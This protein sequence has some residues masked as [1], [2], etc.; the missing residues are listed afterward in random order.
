MNWNVDTIT[1]LAEVVGA[2]GVIVSLFYL[3]IQIRVN[4]KE[5]RLAAMHEISEGFRDSISTFTNAEMAG[6][7]TRGNEDFD[8]LSDAEILQL[9]AGYQ[10]M[11]RLWEEAFY[12][13]NAGRLDAVIWDGIISEYSSFLPAPSFN[14]IWLLRRDYFPTD[15]QTLVDE[16]M[17][18]H[19]K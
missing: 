8:A 15:F 3:A 19:Q 4:N 12:Q 9:T 14:R 6:V 16:L 11:L 7:A 1:A 10:I 5:A 18:S 17:P 13:N 2:I